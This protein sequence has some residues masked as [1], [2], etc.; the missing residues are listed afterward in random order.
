MM[1]NVYDKFFNDLALDDAKL[2][3]LQGKV[4]Q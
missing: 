3:T 4:I 2:E 1:A